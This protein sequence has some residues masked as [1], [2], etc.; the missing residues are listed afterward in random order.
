[1]DDFTWTLR[2]RT[3]GDGCATAYVRRHQ[4]EVG[5][6]LQFDAEYDRITALEYA[7]G[8]L[9]ADLVNGLAARCRK[10]RLDVDHV[11]ALVGGTLNNPLTYLDVVGEEGHPGLERITIRVYV[12]SADTRAAVQR[13]WEEVLARSPLA[14]T[15]AAAVRLDLTLMV[16]P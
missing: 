4:F 15:L 2:V 1:M 5:A 12:S 3:T 6:P 7:L 9:G 16:V 14:R 13:V 8:A 10:Q 11:E